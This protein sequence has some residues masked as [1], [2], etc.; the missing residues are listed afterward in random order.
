MRDLFDKTSAVDPVAAARRGAR[1]ALRRRFYDTV[2]VAADDA[3]GDDDFVVTLDGKPAHTPAGAILAAPNLELAR[4]L[5]AEW[6]AQREKIDP[7][8]MP[9]TRLANTIIDGVAKAPGR[10]AADIAKYLA[11]DLLFY[12]AEAPPGLVDLQKRHW[13]PILDWANDAWGARFVLQTGIVHVEQ[14]AAA[15]AAVRAAIPDD[16]WRLGAIHVITTLTGS[17]LIALAMARGFLPA[18]EAW[19][20][21]HVDEDWNIA[22]WGGDEAALSRRAFRFA[23]FSAA[24]TVLRCCPD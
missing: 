22:Q 7:A 6:D 17:A 13:D 9:L 10:V 5:A 11:S 12:R 24:A 15:L 4:A 19:R 16:P 20:A 3:A 8:K 18:D 14:P 2:S 23:E 21:A 1:P